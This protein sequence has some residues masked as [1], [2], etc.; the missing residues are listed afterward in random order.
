[1]AKSTTF[2]PANSNLTNQ[3][4]TKKT[5][6]CKCKQKHRIIILPSKNPPP[7]HYPTRP[8]RTSSLPVTP[9]PDRQLHGV[10]TRTD[11]QPGG[12][13]AGVP[14]LSSTATPWRR[15]SNGLATNGTQADQQRTDRQ[16]GG[17]LAGVPTSSSVA[18]VGSATPRHR[19]SNGSATNGTQTD[20]QLG[21][22]L[23]GF[24]T[25]SVA[26]GPLRVLAACSGLGGATAFGLA[27]A[28]CRLGQGR[29]PVFQ[30]QLKFLSFFG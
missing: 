22:G 12:G 19:N 16:P 9:R 25:W 24:P 14:T 29:N 7:S 5:Q 6:K 30:Q 11:R 26:A 27:V 18:T 23:V 2:L 21:V 10:G 13:L 17:G 3:H 20:R 8:S 15:N 1:V 28:E 4:E